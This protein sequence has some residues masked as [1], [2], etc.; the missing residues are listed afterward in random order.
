M[1][2]IDANLLIYAVSSD[3]PQHDGAKSWLN[4]TLTSDAPVGLPWICLL[5]FM[6]ITT[7]RGIPKSIRVCTGD[8]IG[9][10]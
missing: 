3:S 4:E 6:R 10:N 5:A 8:A 1:L 9:Y 7:R 2:L